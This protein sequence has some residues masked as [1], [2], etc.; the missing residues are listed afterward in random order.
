MP[1]NNAELT[2]EQVCLIRLSLVEG[3]GPVKTNALLAAFGT[4]VGVYAAGTSQLASVQGIG[5]RLA[6]TIKACDEAEARLY[7][8]RVR[9]ANCWLLYRDDDAFPE[10]LKQIPDCPALLSIRG[11]LTE[12]DRVS[13][14]IVGSRRCSAYGRRMAQQLSRDLAARGI[15]VVSGLARG[16]DSVAHTAALEVGGRTLAVLAS[17]V[18]N[19]YPPEHKDL[20]EEVVKAGALISEAELEGPPIGALFPQRNRIISGMSLGIVVV[21]AALRSGAL[22]T[23]NHALD[24]NRDVFAVPGRVG[25]PVSEG[26]NKLIKQGAIAVTGVEDILEVIG[27]IETPKSGNLASVETKG[28]QPPINAT[29]VEKKLW[30]AIG[31]DDAEFEDMLSQTGLRASEASSALLMMEMRKLIRRLPG[32]RYERVR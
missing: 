17:G 2:P 20:A 10:R 12:A 3:L 25:D 6:S 4:A 1:D 11:T 23:A 9:K 15:T 29:D 14:A 8:D 27:P 16:I 18:A 28:E 31:R 26:C 32:N 30:T 22:S 7:A 21:E 5:N 24:Q 19:I 13:V